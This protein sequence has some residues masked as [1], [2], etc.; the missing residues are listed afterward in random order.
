M[1][2]RKLVSQAEAEAGTSIILRDWSSLR[3]KQAILALAGG[4]APAYLVIEPNAVN[5]TGTLAAVAF[6]TSHDKTDATVIDHDIVTNNTRIIA[7]KA[8]TLMFDYSA[9]YETNTLGNDTQIELVL[10]VN[11]TTEKEGSR[12][13]FF[14]YAESNKET[15]TLGHIHYPIVLAVDD[16]VEVMHREMAG[17]ARLKLEGKLTVYKM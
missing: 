11:G 4:S 16:Y 12:K 6:Q 5:L 9:Y 15:F 7:K 17:S 1:S 2:H 14:N 8:G 3:V 10:K 13:C